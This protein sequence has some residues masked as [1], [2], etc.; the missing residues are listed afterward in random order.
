MH[1][2]VL[3]ILFFAVNNVLWKKNLLHC[4]VAFLVGYRAFFTCMGSTALLLYFYGFD[5]YTHQPLA[6]ITLG[7][8]FGMMGL[9]CML[10]VLKKAPLQWL[11]I[12]N[13][14]GIFFTALYLYFFENSRLFDSLAGL[15]LIVLGFGFYIYHNREQAIKLR[16]AQ[17][18]SLF[19]MTVF[20][21]VSSLI[22]WKN[23][24]SDVPPLLIIS[25]QE[26]VVFVS[27]LVV[28]FSTSKN[29]H[30]GGLISSHLYSVLQMALVIFFAL[31]FSFLGLGA[32]NPVVSSILFLATPLLTILFGALFFK[33]R[34]SSVNIATIAIIAVGAFILHY[35]SS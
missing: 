5:V 1:F 11:G 25:N 27:A 9:F 22:H 14:S 17:H 16:L 32:T 28:Y 10:F 34:I 29:N 31:Y 12:Y 13:L 19:C 15:A 3:S 8:V 23:L 7:S 20:F 6:R 21:G 18:V 4:S 24:G 30:I 35:Q 2:I 33:E 26:L